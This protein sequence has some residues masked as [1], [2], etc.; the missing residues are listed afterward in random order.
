LLRS[1]CRKRIFKVIYETSCSLCS[2]PHLHTDFVTMF[3]VI[4]Y[5]MGRATMQV[6]EPKQTFCIRTLWNPKNKIM[7]LMKTFT[8][9]ILYFSVLIVTHYA[10]IYNNTCILIFYISDLDEITECKKTFVLLLFNEIFHCS[11]ILLFIL[12]IY[13]SSLTIVLTSWYYR[14]ILKNNKYY[15]ST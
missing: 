4:I 8:I 1:L 2:I 5:Y 6:N 15:F 7:I 14:I 10:G 3:D 12:Y 11:D 13:S 9:L